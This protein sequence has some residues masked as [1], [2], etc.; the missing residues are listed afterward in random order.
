[1]SSNMVNLRGLSKL[2][3]ISLL[4]IIALLLIGAFCGF[5][6][7]LLFN[8]I[9][10]FSGILGGT[11]LISILFPVPVLIF[12]YYVSERL[13]I[14]RGGGTDILLRSFHY[15]E[16][17]SLKET[18][19]YFALSLLTI[20]L[21][22]T[23]GPEGPLLVL[24]AGMASN[25]ASMLRL[26]G[27]K[28][29]Y[30]ILAGAS[31]G[32]SASF[33]APL[34]GILFALEIPY[35]RDLEAPVFI[36]AA[37]ASITAYIFSHL[38]IGPTA[39][40]WK[41]FFHTEINFTVVVASLI[42]GLMC[43]LAVIFTVEVMDAVDVASRKLNRYAPVVAGIVITSLVFL[44]PDSRGDIVEEF[45][46]PGFHAYIIVLLSLLLAR[47]VTTTFTVKGGGLGGFFRA[48]IFIGII[49]GRLLNEIF[50]ASGFS[51]N[52]YVIIISAVAGVFAGLNNTLLTSVTLVAEVVGPGMLVPTL[53]SSSVAYITS[54]PWTV[55]KYQIPTRWNIAQNGVRPSLSKLWIKSISMSFI[56]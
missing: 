40:P 11:G 29:K 33:Q 38:L 34:T 51:I 56:R 39:R 28:R 12:S 17:I 53:I 9:S 15:S 16:S 13:K 24:G 27:D 31:A 20:G 8:G 7:Y 41:Y 5:S 46:N 2:L 43:T 32:I 55:H 3:S 48:W 6:E 4:E 10:Y 23:L 35:M 45:M 44:I 49:L 21:I 54:L 47:I 42:V 25:I 52:Q 19:G 37:I 14:R 26:S 22:G 36:H 30:L 18:L 50:V 1:M